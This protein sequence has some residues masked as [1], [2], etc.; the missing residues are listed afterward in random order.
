[1]VNISYDNFYWESELF[2]PPNPF[3]DD[4]S[5]DSDDPME[6]ELSDDEEPS[7][8]IHQTNTRALKEKLH[9]ATVLPTVKNTLHYMQS[10]GLNLPLFLHALSWGNENC[11]LDEQV[12]YARTSLMVSKELPK[13]LE[14]WYCPPWN[15][16]KGKRAAG[17]WVCLQRFAGRWV[18]DVVEWEMKV[19]APA[20]LSS[21]KELSKEHLISFDFDKLKSEVQQ[22]APVLWELL[23]NTAYRPKQE[24][25]NL[26]KDPDIVCSSFADE[27]GSISNYLR[28]IWQ[29]ILN[30][31]SQCHYTRSH[32]CGRVVKLWAIYLK[33][34]GTPCTDLDLWWAING[35]QMCMEQY[36]IKQC[37][38]SSERFKQNLLSHRTIMSTYHC[39]CFC[40]GC[41]TRATLSVAALRRSGFY[42]KTRPFPGRCEQ[43]ISN[44]PSG[45]KQDLLRL[46]WTS[47]WRWG[48]RCT[49][50]ST[51]E[52]SRKVTAWLK[53]PLSYWNAPDL[54]ECEPASEPYMIFDSTRSI[55]KLWLSTLKIWVRDYRNC[56]IILRTY[57]TIQQIN[58]G[59]PW[60][61][62]NRDQEPGVLSGT[63]EVEARNSGFKPQHFT[64]TGSWAVNEC[65]EF[66]E[67]NW[68]CPY[69]HG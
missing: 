12:Q 38:R 39:G 9:A 40:R 68:P 34:C 21:P 50:R 35:W 45:R 1:M 26:R 51:M 46:W 54:R 2:D 55:W 27:I 44:A 65:W 57:N 69:W 63:P 15:H 22:D 61:Y 7:D 33:V 24:K 29:V 52:K 13:I 53:L 56:W 10:Q 19:T 30:M 47:G 60:Q 31:F 58:R 6:S 32:H 36:P 48:D 49:N 41:I 5:E 28:I 62:H 42:L 64:L 25:T 23:R 16:H 3:Y 4:S 8:P 17:A 11:I 66:D 18:R 20:F 43:G 14:R 59:Y 67:M 37:K